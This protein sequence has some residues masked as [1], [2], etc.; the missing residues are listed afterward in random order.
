MR[1]GIAP[2]VSESPDVENE[3]HRTIQTCA[4]E[5]KAE[6]TTLRRDNSTLVAYARALDMFAA[7]FPGKLG[8]PDHAVKMLAHLDYLRAHLR[9]TECGNQSRTIRNHF[10]YCTT[11]LQRFGVKNPLEQE[12]TDPTDAVAPDTLQ[13]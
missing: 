3:D 8:A 1:A 6:L 11:F 12:E 9:R 7:H 4:E 5:F 10:D 13:P 2:P